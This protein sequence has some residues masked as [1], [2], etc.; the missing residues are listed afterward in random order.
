MLEF[1]D[2]A[3]LL[4]TEVRRT[5]FESYDKQPS[6]IPQIYEV[7]PFGQAPQKMYWVDARAVKDTQGEERRPGEDVKQVSAREARR[8]PFAWKF[9]AER[10][11]VPDE[12][13]MFVQQSPDGM[14]SPNAAES[15]LEHLRPQA[16]WLGEER[17]RREE[18]IAASAFNNG[19]L[20]AGH[21]VFNQTIE[22]FEDANGDL[23]YDGKPAFN[24]TGN[25][26]AAIDGTTYYNGLALGLSAA[27][28]KT[29][30]NLMAS[31]NAFDEMGRSIHLRPSQII[32]PAALRHDV[33]QI[34]DAG[35]L[36]GSANND[37]NT[38]RDYEV[39]DWNFLTD[40]DAWFIQD[41][42]RKAFVWYDGG[43]PMV[44]VEESASNFSST[45]AVQFKYALNL[46][47]WRPIVG[48]NFA[49]S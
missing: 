8:I 38:F 15:I 43:P 5:M 7:V 40:S 42:M 10:L 47:D 34:R 29:A 2:F 11:V 16:R 36:A 14:V 19:G 25:A 1:R 35:G 12:L 22:V 39:V 32:V 24:L 3:G 28:W 41:P 46:R 21:S 49:T 30:D 23:C 27:N 13:T 37:A 26:R 48:S 44:K 6:R 17:A 31:T 9:I 33:M 20:T 45:I 4:R 18:E